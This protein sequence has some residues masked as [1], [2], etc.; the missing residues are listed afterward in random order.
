MPPSKHAFAHASVHVCLLRAC[1]AFVRAS[2]LACVCLSLPGA[3]ARVMTGASL[4][5]CM[6]ALASVHAYAQV[7]IDFP[8]RV[9]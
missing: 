6:R 7:N 9:L 1:H 2:L 4:S 5:A 3:S 8:A